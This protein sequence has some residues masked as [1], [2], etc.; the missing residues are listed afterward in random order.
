MGPKQS[1]P[2]VHASLSTAEQTFSQQSISRHAAYDTS[3][4]LS[5]SIPLAVG[6]GRSAEHGDED[7]DDSDY[8]P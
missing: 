4:S 5:G 3:Q 8:L 7:D 6:D 1:T 2:V